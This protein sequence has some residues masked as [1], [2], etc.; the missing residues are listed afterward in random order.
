MKNKVHAYA[1]GVHLPKTASGSTTKKNAVYKSGTNKQV[2]DSHVL[3]IPK[4]QGSLQSCPNTTCPLFPTGHLWSDQFLS[5][6]HGRC[7]APSSLKSN[8]KC[9]HS[10]LGILIGFCPVTPNKNPIQHYE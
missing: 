1:A 2:A 10:D 4:P 3:S 7:H 8:P 9:F 5:Q 6:D